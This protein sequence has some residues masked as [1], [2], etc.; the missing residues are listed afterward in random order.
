M[1][2]SAS[3][4][5]EIAAHHSTISPLVLR[6]A[7]NFF[8]MDEGGS[9]TVC[10]GN[11]YAVHLGHVSKVALRI[12]ASQAVELFQFRSPPKIFTRSVLLYRRKSK[13]SVVDYCDVVMQKHVPID[14]G[15]RFETISE[16]DFQRLY[17]NVDQTLV[18]E[19]HNSLPHEPTEID[20]VEYF[21]IAIQQTLPYVSDLVRMGWRYEEIGRYQTEQI[22]F[23]VKALTM[24][25][26]CVDLQP[27]YVQV[28]T[29]GE[30]STLVSRQ[31]LSVKIPLEALARNVAQ[32]GLDPYSD[33]GFTAD[34]VMQE[35]GVG[36]DKKSFPPVDLLLSSDDV[37]ALIGKEL[38]IVARHEGLE[39]RY[40]FDIS[41]L[42]EQEQRKLVKGLR[43][44]GYV[45]VSIDER[46]IDPQAPGLVKQY[47]YI[48]LQDI[49]PGCA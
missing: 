39:Q 49:F 42:D 15:I 11:T 27:P 46:F 1:A 18:L 25:G 36:E 24:K 37:M 48:D 5:C 33:D 13:D 47:L 14:R 22:A 31:S 20:V 19:S 12:L 41:R 35:W 44:L 2:L 9:G 28:V 6:E 26:F 45:R 30:T 21:K 4:Y 16:S 38:A 40:A 43:K 23:A 32:E 29:D 17:R 3:D 10:I 7:F 8:S 34:S